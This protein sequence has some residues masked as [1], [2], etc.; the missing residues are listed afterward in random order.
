MREDQPWTEA[1]PR[2]LSELG[3]GRSRLLS[4]ACVCAARWLCDAQP[5]WGG[6]RASFPFLEAS[7]Q[8]RR[9]ALRAA[10]EA[11]GGFPAFAEPASLCGLR[12]QPLTRQAALP[13]AR[14][15]APRGL[16]A[17]FC[18]PVQIPFSSCFSSYPIHFIPG[19][20]FFCSFFFVKT[21]DMISILD[22]GPADTLGQH[23]VFP[24]L[25]FEDEI[26]QLS[27]GAWHLRSLRS[28]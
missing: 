10:T 1:L 6:R 7:L 13:C 8:S 24:T 18:L 19:E 25:F 16:P 26:K 27:H 11:A 12:A 28:S 9:F 15:S 23:N 17:L 21:A 2:Q 3:A 22:G 20:R 14:A 5:H 4:G